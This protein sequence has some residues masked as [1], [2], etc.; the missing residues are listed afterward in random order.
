MGISPLKCS[1][2][3]K[4]LVA[5]N[6]FIPETIAASLAFSSGKMTALKPSFRACKT[7]ANTPFTGT[8]PPSRESSPKIKYCCKSG[9][10]LC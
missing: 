10:S 6:T 4:I 5:P 2:V 9:N 8:K 3:C 7:E 1:T